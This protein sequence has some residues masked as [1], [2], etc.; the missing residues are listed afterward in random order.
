MTVAYPEH[1]NLCADV[2]MSY[3]IIED[4]PSVDSLP[5]TPG[6]DQT[7]TGLACVK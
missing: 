3:D 6:E 7:A 4:S 2:L 1:S 5:H